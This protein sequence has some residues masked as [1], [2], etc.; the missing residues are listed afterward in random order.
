[1]LSSTII[2]E[3]SR[4]SIEI[5]ILQSSFSRKIH[6]ICLEYGRLKVASV[7]NVDASLE[8]QRHHHV[9]FRISQLVPMVFHPTRPLRWYRC[10]LQAG[11][12]RR[13]HGHS[14]ATTLLSLVYIFLRLP[15]TATTP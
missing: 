14:S 6:T 2:E 13:L 15:L 3:H 8:Q 7:V 12:P 10:L 11:G 1:M 4:N 9:L 5:F